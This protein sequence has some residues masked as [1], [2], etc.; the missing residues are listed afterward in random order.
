MKTRVPV[1]MLLGVVAIGAPRAR[2]ADERP[3]A[4]VFEIEDRSKT[5]RP[6]ARD[7]LND[8]LSSLLTKG[9]YQVVP[10]SQ[11]K[12]RLTD[13]KAG[14]YK[15]C[16]DQA[17]QIELG[18]ELAAQK[19]LASQVLKLGKQCKVTVNLY[20]LKRATSEGAGTHSGS[21]G[22]DDI[23]ASMERAMADLLRRPAAPAG[24]RPAAADGPITEVG[25]RIGAYEQGEKEHAYDIGMAY[26]HGHS[27]APQNFTKAKQWF[28]KAAAHGDVAAYTE[29]GERYRWGQG[30]RK[31]AKEAVKWFRKAAEAGDPVGQ[32]KL[33]VMIHNGEG[34]EQDHAKAAKWYRSACEKGELAEPCANLGSMYSMGAG[35]VKRDK[36]EALRWYLK[37]HERGDD[38]VAPMIS[39]IYETG[40]EGVPADKQKAVDW[41]IE[42]ARRNYAP[43]MKSLGEAYSGKR[44]PPLCAP[45]PVEAYKWLSVYIAKEYA[46]ETAEKLLAEVKAVLGP[47]DLA[48]AEKEAAELIERYVTPQD[49]EAKAHY[50]A[51]PEE[52]R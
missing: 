7:Q 10:R 43:A 22:E 8:Y 17:C 18:R 31:N 1:V 25:E 2:G 15:A 37:A 27:G 51:H 21:C 13:A 34:A 3:I 5:L 29:L 24:D 48:R 40:A 19:S 45:N 9:G 11:L 46:T 14:S 23:V 26:L 38:S 49:R 28:A 33:G 20:D 39:L 30:A 35:V 44:Y 32:Y 6:A 42:G 36:A 4:V 47:A 50:R 16:Y 12:E 41:L 52:Y